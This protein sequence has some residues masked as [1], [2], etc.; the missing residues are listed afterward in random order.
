MRLK[1]TILE[2]ME[3]RKNERIQ[4]VAE[5]KKGDEYF[6]G[7][8]IMAYTE[9]CEDMKRAFEEAH[10]PLEPEEYVNLAMRTND[11][12]CTERMNEW[13]QGNATL[14]TV[15]FPEPIDTGALLNACLGLSGEVGELLDM[16]KKWIFHKTPMDVD[17][18][19]KELGDVC[20]YIALFCHS[21]GLNLEKVMEKNIEKLKARYPEGF[22][23]EKANNRAEGDI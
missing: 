9:G 13:Q 15:P 2:E 12:K 17:H 10:V 20:W 5:N 18:L 6:K 21:T 3:R 23:T 22:D 7:A 11:G 16:I 1:E 8:V 19:E 4:K 14:Q